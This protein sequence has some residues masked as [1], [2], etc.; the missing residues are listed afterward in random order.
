MLTF[1]GANTGTGAISVNSGGTLASLPG[2]T[3]SLAGAV[4]DNTGGT[5]A[6]GGI[7]NTTAATLSLG[8]TLALNNASVLHFDF[9]AGGGAQQSL[10]T[11]SLSSSSFT[12]TG[13]PFL[14]V[15]NGPTTAGNYRLIADP[16][17]VPA[18]LSNVLITGTPSG[19]SYSLNGT[20]DPGF[21][22]LTVQSITATT[23]TYNGGSTQ[24]APGATASFNTNTN[25]TPNTVPGAGSTAVF[26]N[27]SGTGTHTVTLDG[28]QRVGALTLNPGTGNVYAFT[29]GNAGT[30]SV[31]SN[32]T[33]S[34]GANTFA[35]PLTLLGATTVNIDTSSDSASS[36]TI[37]SAG[38]LA[39][40][41]AITK[42]GA[43]L[44]NVAGQASNTGGGTV[45]AGTLQ[46]SN[47]TTAN[48]LAG[49]YAVNSGGT[50]RASSVAG[51]GGVTSFNA[52]TAASVTLNNGGVLA[53]N[54]VDTT[55]ATGLFVRQYTGASGNN[56]AYNYTAAAGSSTTITALTA[57]NTS[58]IT[59]AT[60]N[61]AFDITGKLNVTQTGTYSF[62]LNADDGAR[63]Y[64]DG[65]L[66]TNNDTG[67]GKGQGTII[68]GQGV[69][70]SAG[71]HDVRVQE[72]NVGGGGGVEV[73]YAGPTL[74]ATTGTTAAQTAIPITSYL[75]PVTTNT[76]VFVALPNAIP[77]ANNVAVA[78][79]AASTIDLGSTNGATQSFAGVLLNPAAGAA[80]TLNSG[81]TLTLTATATGQTRLEQR[82]PVAR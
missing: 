45:S 50:L 67:A 23:F 8:S 30:L 15:N 2:G 7:G 73:T 46:F 58:L 42:T 18:N 22:D 72:I 60:A 66:V 38:S 24:P 62:G 35:A 5:I 53:L 57:T 41:G 81:S 28:S 11:L 1:S 63:L 64:V 52:L 33:N 29:P 27:L 56:S 49:T 69:P 75:Q 47:T 80:L 4:T 82:R 10:D 37:T 31:E 78:A 59:T 16:G 34:S 77:M 74:G 13:N 25:W 3:V 65:Q 17:T 26:P 43:G 32:I 9:P 40:S 14:Q 21:I 51:G 19:V 36:L 12:I 39:G 48:A 71:L 20:S 79:G 44:F 6:P 61:T 68:V 55:T 76:T 70:L 54:P